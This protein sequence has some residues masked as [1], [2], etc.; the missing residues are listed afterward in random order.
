MA[1]PQ[2][3][4]TDNKAEITIPEGARDIDIM[5]HCQP[6]H[7][8]QRVHLK[9]GNLDLLLTGFRG[10]SVRMTQPYD[11]KTV[12][13]YARPES[14]SLQLGQPGDDLYLKV[15]GEGQVELK[16]LSL[17]GPCTLVVTFSHA[18][19]RTVKPNKVEV[20]GPWDNG[21]EQGVSFSCP[22]G[23]DAIDNKLSGSDVQVTWRSR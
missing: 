1:D 13:E 2:V 5:I 22:D 15:T 21:R 14:G 9:G 8:E 7:V 12:F 16:Q 17:T 11:Q 6:G 20:S 4:V 10:S 3:S 23:E 19:G 18:I